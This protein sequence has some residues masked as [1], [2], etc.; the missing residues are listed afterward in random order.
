MRENRRAL[1]AVGS[2]GLGDSRGGLLGM[3]GLFIDQNSFKN[4]AHFSDS[5]A[6]FAPFRFWKNWWPTS[7]EKVFRRRKA[8]RPHSGFPQRARTPTGGRER[9]GRSEGLKRRWLRR[10]GARRGTAGYLYLSLS[11]LLLYHHLFVC[12]AVGATRAIHA[13]RV[14]R[15]PKTEGLLFGCICAKNAKNRRL[16]GC[17]R[18]VW[19]R[20]PSHGGLS[21]MEG[22]FNAQNYF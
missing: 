14:P 11:L 1:D 12:G 17:R 13:R 9:D 7:L 5:K 22:L 6:F 10:R 19:I 8:L 18:I 2:F 3:Q 16:F 15:A 20:G 4:P 21:E